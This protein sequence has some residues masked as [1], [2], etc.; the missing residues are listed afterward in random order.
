MKKYEWVYPKVCRKQGARNCSRPIDKIP[1]CP[2]SY[3][4]PLFADSTRESSS[5]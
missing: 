3:V 2:L 5:Q 4:K 1:D